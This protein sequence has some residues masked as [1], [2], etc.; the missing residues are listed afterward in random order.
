MHSLDACVIHARYFWRTQQNTR[1]LS[2]ETSGSSN[3]MVSRIPRT[4]Q[5][6]GLPSSEHLRIRESLDLCTFPS[7]GIL[8]TRVYDEECRLLGC[9]AQKTPFFIVTVVKTSN[10]TESTMFQ[11]L[12]LFASSGERTATS[13][14]LVPLER[15]NLTTG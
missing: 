2:T 9:Y 12:C 3:V 15:A 10:L 7:S 13:T 8:K 6:R 5:S 4:E 14:L 11:K 1:H